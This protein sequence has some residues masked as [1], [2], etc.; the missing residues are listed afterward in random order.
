MRF[1][2]L[3]H[4]IAEDFSTSDFERALTGRG[5]RRVGRLA[6]ML[7]EMG[8][9]PDAIFSSPRIRARQTAEIVADALGQ[10]VTTSDAV[11]FGFDLDNVADLTKALP[12]AADVMFVGHNPDMSLVVAEL[13]G[14]DLNM[15]KGGLARVDVAGRRLDRGELVWLIAPR[16]TGALYPGRASTGDKIADASAPL[17]RLIARRWSPVGFDPGRQISDSALRGIL[18]AGRW[19]ASSYNMQPWRF[20]V[21]RRQDGVEFDK[22]LDLLM[23]GN[24]AWA[25][26]AAVLMIAAYHRYGRGDNLNKH[27]AHDLGQAIAQMSLQALEYDIYTHQMAGFYPDKARAAYQ[28]PEAYEPFT[29]VAM[30]YRADETS[31]LSE[32]QRERDTGARQRQPL[33]ELVFSGAW[34]ERVSFLE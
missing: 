8:L 2:F 32:Q 1:Y 26:H 6:T 4:G 25:R 13:T 23:A 31:H 21:A 27:G 33:S 24:Q 14:C 34:E 28:I 15:K 22:M 16:V 12:G 7:R 10:S 19:A 30:G 11:N 9:K 29:A 18:E 17:N 5:K 20:I 3:R